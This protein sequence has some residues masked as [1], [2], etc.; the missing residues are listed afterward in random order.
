MGQG[1]T[2][3][4]EVE[5]CQQTA[6]PT[7]FACQPK[8]A[9]NSLLVPENKAGVGVQLRTY[10]LCPLT[11]DNLLCLES[12]HYVE[13]WFGVTLCKQLTLQSLLT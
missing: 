10:S 6:V 12:S 7:S 13:L 4:P 3:D 11:P 5:I 8:V 9:L 2:V 1:C